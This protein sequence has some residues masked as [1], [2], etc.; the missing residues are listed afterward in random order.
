M[1]E[2]IDCLFIGHNEMRF[3]EYESMV[4]RMGKKSPAYRDL[5]LNYICHNNIH[6]FT[7]IYN[8][9]SDNEHKVS[10]GDVFSA[11]ISYLGTY[12]YRRGC[13]F[14]F[15]NS[16]QRD[17][18]LLAEKLM[19]NNIS[20]IAIVTTLYTSVFPILEIMKFIKMYNKSAKVIIG[21]PFIAT[22]VRNQTS[23]VLE[24]LFKTIDAD[25]Y[26]NSSQGEESLVEILTAIKDNNP[27]EH[28][29]NIF[30]RNEDKYVGNNCR[31]ENNILE[32]NMI[33]WTIFNGRIE[34]CVSI[35]TAISC[36]FACSFCGFP[37]HAGKYQTVSVKALEEELNSLMKIGIK[38]IN[39]IDDT[40]NIPQPRFKEI[41]KMMIKNQYNFNWNSY[42]RC[43]F[44]DAE[45][46][47]LMRESGCQGV[48]LG[49]ESGSQKILD[50]MNKNVTIEKYEKG[51]KLLKDYNIPSFASFI[52]GFPGETE[53]TVKETIEFIEK[54]KPTF[55]RAQLWYC[56]QITPI[57]EEKDKYEISGS[58]FNW[59]HKTMNSD[60][61][62]DIIEGIFLNIK[63]S[64]WL[65]QYN[66]D[67]VGIFNLLQR[68]M[69]IEQVKRMLILFNNE[70]KERLQK[71]DKKQIDNGN[72]EKL[73]QCCKVNK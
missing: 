44:I 45:T 11:A 2:N 39:F 6:T 66:F 57:F 56:E 40:F 46:V 15:I 23:E 61:A 63:N 47:E 17:K 33:D 64:V 30:Y 43:Q 41:L 19:N 62:C 1:Y 51:I 14:D 49:I 4:R 34:D 48:F 52:V 8:M 72:V 38:N 50:N 65:P 21:G 27:I 26:I 3:N 55:F 18:D 67:F 29:D 53:E 37:Q 7:D 22:Q 42:L 32:N 71:I 54:N 70:I 25:F 20:T 58:Q 36:P 5:N 31:K 16:F 12:L 28:I 24:Y 10:L 59:S 73:I 68:G 60:T 13:T 9:F 69:S 35:R